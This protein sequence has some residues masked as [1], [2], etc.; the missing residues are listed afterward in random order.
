[1][2]V[3]LSANNSSREDQRGLAIHI[4][5]KSA[6][7]RSFRSEAFACLETT[8]RRRHTAISLCDCLLPDP[9]DLLNRGVIL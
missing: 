3:A 6:G 1:M 5:E 7:R 8:A 4:E 2:N 9:H